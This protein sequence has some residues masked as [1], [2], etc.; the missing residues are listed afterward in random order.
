MDAHAK[1]CCSSVSVPKDTVSNKQVW[2]VKTE[3]N[4][5]DTKQVQL[6]AFPFL[7]LPTRIQIHGFKT[8]PKPSHVSN[9]YGF[10]QWPTLILCPVQN[11][12][13]TRTSCP[14]PLYFI[15]LFYLHVKCYKTMEIFWLFLNKKKSWF[16]NKQPLSPPQMLQL[17]P[18]QRLY[19]CS[20]NHATN[21][22]T[23]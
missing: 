16:K 13:C 18:I 14:P 19:L 6:S 20:K 23:K 12:I 15:L 10:V 21:K 8:G 22:Q 11:L 2:R 1:L 3:R 17:W 5:N 7:L 4:R 9:A